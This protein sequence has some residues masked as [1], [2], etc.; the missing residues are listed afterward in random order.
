FT[1]LYIHRDVSKLKQVSEEDVLA[2][3]SHALCPTCEGSGLNPEVL[4][5]KINGF[6]IAEFNQLELTELLEELSD[7]EWPVGFSLAQQAMSYILQQVLMGV[8][9][10]GLSRNINNIV[11]SRILLSNI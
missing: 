7:I 6:N 2:M 1:R 5:C 3:T 10:C 8:G 4:A 9:Y 11:C